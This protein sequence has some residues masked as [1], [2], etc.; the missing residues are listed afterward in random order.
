[1]ETELLYPEKNPREKD[2]RNHIFP[3]QEMEKEF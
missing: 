1:M 3:V 2:H